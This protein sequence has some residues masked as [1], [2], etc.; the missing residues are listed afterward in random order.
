MSIILPEVSEYLSS[1]ARS[2]HRYAQINRGDAPYNRF[3]TLMALD[4][5]FTSN[6][7]L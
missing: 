5:I 4:Y 3:K 7:D 2:A 1:S 6:I